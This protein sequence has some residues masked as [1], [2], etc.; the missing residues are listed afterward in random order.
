MPKIKLTHSV[1][2]S[3][4]TTKPQEDYWDTE[5]RVKRAQFGLRVF[6]TGKKVFI[7]RY[8]TKD[9]RKPQCN[10]GDAACLSLSDARSR[11]KDIIA[12]TDGA[13]DPALQREIYKKS[14]TFT[15]LSEEFI[16]YKEGM[17][18]SDRMR[19]RTVA[20]YARVFRVDLQPKIG[21]LRL[22]DVTKKHILAIL[23]EIGGT[24]NAPAQARRTKA[25]LHNVFR[26]ALERDYISF[27]PCIGL[28]KL[29]A[30]LPRTR[31]LSDEEIY[32]LWKE[33]ENAPSMTAL[34]LRLTLLTGQRPGE[35]AGMRQSE[36]S[37][38]KDKGIVWTIPRSRTKNKREQVVPLSNLAI[39]LL[40]KHRA[41][42]K[43]AW[44][45]A[46]MLGQPIDRDI[47]FFS[48]NGDSI[49]YIGKSCGRIRRR[50]K[51]GR[52]TPHDLRR[53]CATRLGELGFLDE[54]IA[55]VL[56]HAP[57]SVTGRHYNHHNGFEKKKEAL[58]EWAKQL[59][60]IVNCH[61]EK[62][63]E[64]NAEVA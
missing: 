28:P 44:K 48:R 24:R 53:T 8:R 38:C 1:V 33:T 55:K 12:E 9:G 26:Y 19:A 23:D 54:V 50:A 16:T 58:D 4:K 15:D 60:N 47:V 49:A 11:F 63:E 34:I 51:L 62:T 21:T 20:E 5:T 39:Q 17:I 52:F 40:E 37:E 25:I 42:L 36:I 35:V 22:P 30:M 57:T 41:L 29:S 59:S 27:S 7:A 64:R 13:L 6:A 14:R 61:E 3:L 43:E 2:Q 31:V 45:N 32:A 10:I 56:N 46:L 18:K